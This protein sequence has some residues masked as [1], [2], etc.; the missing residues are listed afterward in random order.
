MASLNGSDIDKNQKLK[1]DNWHFGSFWG[2][3]SNGNLYLAYNDIENNKRIESGEKAKE[4]NATTK[5]IL[6]QTQISPEGK[7]KKTILS[8]N[9]DVYKI[10]SKVRTQLNK[11]NS[12][13]LFSKR[14]TNRR[15]V[16]VMFGE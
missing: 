14:G 15:L 8:R 13:I 7:V 4:M 12:V 5:P 11:E 6:V 10:S 2:V 3:H 1:E 16:R 9:P